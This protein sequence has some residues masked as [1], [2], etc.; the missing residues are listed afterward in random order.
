MLAV[1]G[2]D[3]DGKIELV[4]S[5]PSEIKEAEGY[6]VIV[7]KPKKESDE[8]FFDYNLNDT[9]EKIAWAVISANAASEWKNHEEEEEIWK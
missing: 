4:E 1:K 7:P 6:I 3:R 8:D 9:K 5:L 2:I